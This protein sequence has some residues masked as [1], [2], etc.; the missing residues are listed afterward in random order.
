MIEIYP[1]TLLN[2]VLFLKYQFEF[3]DYRYIFLSSSIINFYSHL[4]VCHRREAH[5]E[6]RPAAQKPVIL[7]RRPHNIMGT[8]EGETH[9]KKQ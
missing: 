6:L 4:V 5:A 1:K 8:K 2:F 3:D 7:R 9:T